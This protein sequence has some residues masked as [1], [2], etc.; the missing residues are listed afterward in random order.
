MKNWNASPAI[1]ISIAFFA[2]GVVWI[3]L[4]DSFLL[5]LFPDLKDLSTAQTYKGWL[6]VC[7]TTLMLFSI[8]RKMTSAQQKVEREIRQAEEQYRILVEKLPGAVFMDHYDEKQSPRYISPRI[9]DLLGYTAD[10]WLKNDDFWK[11]SLHE[12]DRERVLAED[13]RTNET[14]EPF[15]IEYRL[16]HRNGQYVWIKEDASIIR[17]ENGKPLFW[18]GIFIDITQ[19]KAAQEALARKDEILK[20]VGLAAEQFLKSPKWEES[21]QRVLTRLGETTN[22]SRAYIFKID[23]SNKEKTTVSQAYEW[24]NEGTAPQIDNPELQDIDLSQ[25]GFTRWVE[26]FNQGLPIFGRVSEFPPGEQQLLKSQGI[27]SLICIPIQA[28]NEW[29]GFIGFDDCANER[30]W[31]DAEVDALRAAANTLG[32]AIERKNYEEALA[33]S[34]S[35]YRGLFN[36]VREAVYIQ[37][38]DG[39]F[40][41]VNEGAVQMYGYPREQFIG[42]TPEF[43]SAPGQ[44]DSVSVF[45]AFQR[46]LGGEPQQFEFWGMRSDG[47]IFPKDVRLYRGVYLGQEIVFALAQD[48]TARKQAEEELQKQLR[49]LSV[50]H[51]A[52]RAEASARDSDTLIQQ[53]TDIISDTL[54]SDRC[55]VFLLSGD[56]ISLIPHY[57]CRGVEEE[58]LA[59]P[60]S[61]IDSLSGR[62]LSERRS[63]RVDDVPLETGS[64]QAV[65]SARSILCAPIVSGQKAFGVL[66][67]ESKRKGIFTERDERLLNT[68]TGGMANALERI[69]FV[70]TEQKHRQQAEAL[71]DATLSLT[72][73]AEKETLFDAIFASLARLMDFDSASIEMLD[74][75][76]LKIIAGKNIPEALIGTTY[77]FNEEKWGHRYMLRQPMIIPDVKADERFIKFEETDYIASWMGIP[78]IAQDTLLGFLNLD[79]RT[80]GF[81]NEDHAFILQTFANQT[82]IALE[83]SRLF[84]LEQRRRR[85]AEDLRLATSSLANTLDLESLLRNILDWLET[86]AAYDSASIMLK[87]DQSIHLAASRRLPDEFPVGREFPLTEKWSLITKNRKPLI[88]RDAQRDGIFEKW[89]GSEYIRGWMGVAMFAQDTLIGFINLDSRQVGTYTEE[90]ATRIQTFANQAATAIEKARLFELEKKRRETAEIVRQAATALTNLLDLPSLHKAI[91]EWLHKIAPFDS[92][93]ILEVEEG[94]IRITAAVG[95]PEPEKALNQVF[96]ADNMLCQLINESGQALIIDDCKDDPRFERWGDS[97]HVRGWLGVPLISRGQVIGYI[98]ID[99]HTPHAFTQSDAIAAQT[100]AHLAATSLENVRLYTETRR[101]LEELEMMNRVSTALRAARD[102]NEMFPILLD[103]IQTSIGVDAATILLYDRELDT[104]TPRATSKLTEG[105]PKA[106]F[107]PGEGIIGKVFASAEPYISHEF[108]EDPQAQ[109]ENA[110]FLGKG[111]G[112]ITVPIR[113]ANEVIGV[114]SVGVK[115]PRQ[116]E[117][118]HGRLI[119]TIAEIAGN[120]IYRSNLYEQS[121][122]QVRR[123]TT[124]REMDTA[125]TSSLDLRITLEIITEHLITKMGASAAAIL[126]FNPD[127]QMLDYYAAKGFQ[128]HEPHRTSISIGDEL[129]GQILLNR[130]A[131]YIKDMGGE[132]PSKRE[133]LIP[134]E[135]FTSYFAIPLLSKGAAKGILETYFAEP[136]TPTSDWMD[137]LQTLAGQ[138]TIAID[139]TQ[140]FENLQRT[141]QEISL[142][143]DTTLEGWGKALELRDKE[144]QGHTKRVANLTVELARQMGIP[145]AEIQPIR[146]GTLLHDIGKMG[147]PD[148]ILHKPGHLTP[149]ET[150]EMRKHPQYA[151]DLLAP[152]PY[153]RPILDIPYCHHEWWDGSGYPRGLKGEEIPLAARIFAVIDVWDALLSNRPY[154]AAWEEKDVME[155]ITGLSGKQFDPNVVDAFKKMLETSPHFVYSNFPVEQAHKPRKKTEKQKKSSSKK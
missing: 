113:T 132:T 95:L 86:L 13:E 115:K 74:Q 145:E 124:L 103:E 22:V 107:K 90:H 7:A 85:E 101:R 49:E 8:V 93:S 155:Y 17:D 146:R 70:E 92:A 154:R 72:S 137:F 122:E 25:T 64:R 15:R 79:S 114:I 46:A 110:Q 5:F 149:Q 109:P 30:N 76:F 43:L 81:F 44:N 14:G 66:K 123:L 48:I 6:F 65:G 55:G 153:L 100:F 38:K 87:Q 91:L 4:T 59:A 47:S 104:L 35:S 83:N 31:T 151:Y 144:T 3:F 99:S 39:H 130:R 21:V 105:F 58:P 142:A 20:A 33:N 143:Y 19:Q 41:D 134:A 77:P 120:A 9:N 129:A 36:S 148:S 89:A 16:R 45:R 112:G 139:N 121:E 133:G 12:E 127:S 96:P 98:T 108:I 135:T 62:A 32:T 111:W 40:I 106:S 138:A 11:A 1:K 152:I 126:V 51:L 125:I 52:A 128:H 117:E 102:T 88:I 34:E 42:K 140:L 119:G 54:Y 97:T 73:F 50:L 78:L 147:V 116:L 24:C 82:A 26:S 136:F 80:P 29:W 28:G 27:L 60:L 37:D 141:N 84:E 69:Q 56:G 150:F 10:E 57:S 71:R 67:V 23:K 61:V 75:G 63:I 118:H 68:I 2:A 53:I 18:H 131:I 94:H